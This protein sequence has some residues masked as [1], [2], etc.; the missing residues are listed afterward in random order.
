MYLSRSKRAALVKRLPVVEKALVMLGFATGL[1][2]NELLNLEWGMI[3]PAGRGIEYIS[4]PKEIM[5][6]K[7]RGRIVRVPAEVGDA[8]RALPFTRSERIFPFSRPTASR[9]LRRLLDI[10]P[11]DMR[12]IFI[13]DCYRAIRDLT[14]VSLVAG[15]MDPRT[16]LRYIHGL[17]VGD[18][19]RKV[20]KH[21]ARN[22]PASRPAPDPGRANSRSKKK[23]CSLTSPA[24]GATQAKAA[25]GTGAARSAMSHTISCPTRARK[26]PKSPTIKSAL[27]NDRRKKKPTKSRPARPARLPMKRKS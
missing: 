1:R 24:F 6:G 3:Q 10:A 2:I 14:L 5:K 22:Q 11:H 18:L 19:W 23:T 17:K 13:T 8:L 7:K 21:Q 25:H 16:T 26:A 4:V 9:R 15:H 27:A 12:R 20:H